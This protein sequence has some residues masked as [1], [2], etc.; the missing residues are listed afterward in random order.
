MPMSPRLLRP[1]AAR[2][3]FNFNPNNLVLV[4]D[5]SLE[6]ANNTISVPLNGTVNCTIDWGDGTSES[7]TTTGFKTHTYA[8]PGVYVVQ[9]SGTMTT[10]SYGTGAST[11]NNRAKLVR[12][13]SF[14]NVG[15]TILER[16]FQNC[17]NFIQCPRSLPTTSN[18]TNLLAMFSGCSQFNDARVTQWD[19]SSVTNMSQ[20]FNGCTAF[21]Q[22][23]GGWNTS[24]VTNM[25]LM[26]GA[27]TAFNQPIGSWNTASA[28][29]MSQMFNGCTAFNQDIGGW[30][31]ALVNNMSLMF[32]NATAFNQNIGSWNTAAVTNMSQ[33]FQGCAAFNQDIGGWNTALVNNMSLM[34]FNATAFNQDIGSWNTAAVTNMTQMFQGCAA[35]NQDIGSWNT[36]AVTNM[37]NMFLNATAFN[38]DIGGWNTALV[39][40]MNGMFVGTNHAFAQDISGW[41]IRKVTTMS[42]MFSGNN[43]GT[44]NYDAALED[45]ADLADTDLTIGTTANTSQAITAF[46]QQGAN[47]RVTSNGH[48]LVA[49]SR[50]NISGTTSYNGDFNVLSP[51]AN[52]F[53]IAVTFVA[54]DAT[55]TMKHRRSRNIAAGFGT[56]QYSSGAPTTARGVLTTT[57]DWSI[58]DG[59]Q[60]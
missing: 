21:N 42:G 40:N 47:T 20:M 27:A 33:M 58:T 50:V 19:T 59:G 18:V 32:L 53:D 11:T 57:Y 12:C 31:T 38:Q 22:D 29:N 9:I 23:I 54:N 41:D 14:G 55:G 2:G 30:N 13:L 6:P 1:I 25:A 4:F 44:A 37:S 8:N 7:H 45:W 15:L 16:A 26:F 35:F 28:T 5:T 48:G 49:G 10:L 24:S 34:F 43:W 39:N 52:T 51:T 56:N 3:G 46:A 60:V 36:A 17:V